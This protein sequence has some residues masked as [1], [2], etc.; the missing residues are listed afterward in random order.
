MSFFHSTSIRCEI[1]KQFVWTHTNCFLTPVWRAF[2]NFS[3]GNIFFL[4]IKKSK[5]RTNRIKKMKSIVVL[6]F[7]VALGMCLWS[8]CLAYGASVFADD[9]DDDCV[10]DKIV[11]AEGQIGNPVA[12]PSGHVV[13]YVIII[14]LMEIK[15]KFSFKGYAIGTQ[16]YNCTNLPGTTTPGWVFDAPVATLTECSNLRD[17]GR[18]VSYHYRGPTWEHARDGS[19]I[20]GKALASQPSIYPFSIPSLLVNITSRP[21]TGGRMDKIVLIQRLETHGGVAPCNAPAPAPACTLGARAEVL[22]TSTYIFYK[23]V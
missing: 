18:V 5:V 8:F 17:L 1:E 19:S 11:P 16:N 2:W 20:V 10:R 9:Y 13:A 4:F 23:R 22:Y 21:V 14:S 12:V 6:L 3:G 15:W 7:A